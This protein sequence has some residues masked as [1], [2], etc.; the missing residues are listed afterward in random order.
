MLVI[1][2]PKTSIIEEV[3]AAGCFCSTFKESFR[4]GFISS[5]NGEQEIVVV[6]SKRLD[7]T[8]KP[9]HIGGVSPA[10]AW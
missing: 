8:A 10:A 1:E 6:T 7:N 5:L 3:S 9:V 2:G 4:T